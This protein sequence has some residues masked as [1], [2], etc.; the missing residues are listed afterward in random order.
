MGFS[1]VQPE[2][3]PSE[4]SF[5]ELKPHMSDVILFDFLPLAP[6]SRVTPLLLRGDK[7]KC[8]SQQKAPDKPYGAVSDV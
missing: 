5:E 6:T 3:H 7:K 4:K 2:K 8:G 1:D